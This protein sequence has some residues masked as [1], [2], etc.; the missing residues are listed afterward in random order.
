MSNK[1]TDR[2]LNSVARSWDEKSHLWAEH[3]RKGYDIFRDHFNNPAFF[4]FVGD[5][6]EKL[7]LDL[8]CGEG[9]NTGAGFILK[10]V[11]EPRPTEKA[12][13]KYPRFKRWRD[14]AALF[15]YVVAA[16]PE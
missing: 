6:T 3:V 8:G 10:R 11:E 15:F 4:K 14:H 16:K 5:L 9:Y 12:C 13:R 7:V 1:E 2:L